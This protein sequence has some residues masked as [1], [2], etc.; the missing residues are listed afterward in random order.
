MV[1]FASEDDDVM[2]WERGP[3]NIA[4]RIYALDSANTARG[5]DGLD[6]GFLYAELGE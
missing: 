4:N 6:R 2:R 5:G 3:Q 1:L